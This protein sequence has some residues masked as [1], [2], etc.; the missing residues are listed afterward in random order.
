LKI[1]L[2]IFRANP[3]RGGA[4]R[5]TVDLAASLAHRGHTLTLLSTEFGPPITGVTFTHLPAQAATRLSRYNRFLDSLE[6]HLSTHHYDITH[7]ML[8]VP[9]CDIYHP[10][11]G[12]AADAIQTSHLKQEGAAKRLLAKFANQLNRKRARFAEIEKDLLARSSPP[13]VLCLSD[14]IKSTVLKHYPTL[15]PQLVTL[16]NAV[17]IHKFNPA[18][19]VSNIREKYSIAP[20]EVLGLMIAQDFPRKGL[21]QTLYALSKLSPDEQAKLRLIVVGKQDSTPYA[22]LARELKIDHRVIFAGSTT[23][24]ADFFRAADFFILPTRHDPCSLVVL[25]ALAMGVPVISTIFNGACEIMQNATHGYILKD[26]ADIPS[27]SHAIQNMLH[28]ETRNAMRQACLA[29]RPALAMDSH[30]NRLEE[31]YRNTSG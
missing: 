2:I 6:T 15:G 26:P 31:I 22:A 28:N 20:T 21:P 8:P 13:I 9:E 29:L 12:L 1:C 16:F 23:S 11:A 24:P 4:E 30:L 7:A 19:I 5:Y 14:Y 18:T 3:A 25:E 10:H 17:D 27:L